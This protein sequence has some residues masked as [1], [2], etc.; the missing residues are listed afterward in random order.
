MQSDEDE[1]RIMAALRARTAP[2]K[3]FRSYVASIAGKSEV[4][5]MVVARGA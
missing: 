3:V 4:A 2:V 1:A 5:S